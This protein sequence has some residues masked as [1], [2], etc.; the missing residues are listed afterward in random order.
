ME[1]IDIDRVRDLSGRAAIWAGGYCL[2]AWGN[3]EYSICLLLMGAI[4]LGG[5]K[6]PA[7]TFSMFVNTPSAQK[8]VT[9]SERARGDAPYPS[10]GPKNQRR[11]RRRAAISPANPDPNSHT[12]PGTGTAATSPER[13]AHTLR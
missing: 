4:P 10:Q 2:Y 13:T 5:G 3:Q 6:K 8:P 9:A 11:R 7:A 12:A 1:R